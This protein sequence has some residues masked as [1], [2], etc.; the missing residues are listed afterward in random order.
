MHAEVN[1][2]CARVYVYVCVENRPKRLSARDRRIIESRKGTT[3]YHLRPRDALECNSHWG[4]GWEGCR[5]TVDPLTRF[6]FDSRV[7]RLN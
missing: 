7:S 6:V 5:R 2:E 3:D 4:G 1:R